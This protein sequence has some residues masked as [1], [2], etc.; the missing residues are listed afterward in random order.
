MAVDP[1]KALATPSAGVPSAA[2]RASVFFTTRYLLCVARIFIR[3]SVSCETVM[4]W[5]CATNK[6]R[7][8]ARSF[9]RAS[10]SS[11]FLPLDFM[12]DVSL[13]VE[14]DQVQIHTGTHRRCHGDSLDVFAFQC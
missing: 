14:R 13:R 3:S 8:S 1:S 2:F 5:N 6:F 4:P 9:L 12:M 7:A 11:F 10:S